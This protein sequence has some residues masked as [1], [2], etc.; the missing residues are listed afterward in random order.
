MG[1]GGSH[2]PSNLF[3]K[4]TGVFWSNNT[5]LS[6]FKCIFK[7]ETGNKCLQEGGG[8]TLIGEFLDF[9]PNVL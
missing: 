2:L 5:V 9:F 3:L 8:L 4:K 1:W 6:L 7:V